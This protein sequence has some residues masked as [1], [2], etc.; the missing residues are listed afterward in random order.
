[1]GRIAGRDTRFPLEQGYSEGVGIILD[2]GET[3]LQL[4]N[5]LDG[6]KA[7]LGSANVPMLDWDWPDAAHKTADGVTIRHLGDATDALHSMAE[8]TGERYSLF[9]TPGGVHAHEMT[10]AQTPKKFFERKDVLETNPDPYYVR[11][12][13]EGASALPDHVRHGFEE[14]LFNTRVSPKPN[15]FRKQ[16]D[17]IGLYLGDIGNMDAAYRPESAKLIH[18]SMEDYIRQ[19]RGLPNGLPDPYSQRKTIETM[20]SQLKSVSPHL[21]KNWALA[22]ALLR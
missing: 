22:R 14:G 19:G 21:A 1:M 10:K 9:L 6:R 17:F 3:V 2:P 12:S 16:G 4:Y 18:K 7:Y 20:T 11:L 15:E 8:K 13:K 5:A